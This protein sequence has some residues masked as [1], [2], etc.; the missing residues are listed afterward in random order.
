MRFAL[1]WKDVRPWTT[2]YSKTCSS[3]KVNSPY[4][5]AK[6]GNSYYNTIRV[7]LKC[8]RRVWLYTTQNNELLNFVCMYPDTLE[9]VTDSRDAYGENSDKA[10]H[11]ASMMNIFKDFDPR[12]LAVMGLAESST[13]KNWQLLDMNPGPRRVSGTLCLLGDAALTF[14]PH[15]GQGA[16]S[17]IEDA[18]SLAALF[19]TGTVQKDIPERLQLYNAIRKDRP[20]QIHAISRELGQDLEPGTE[21]ARSYREKS[22][23]EYFPLIFSHDEHDNTTQKLRE[24]LYKKRRVRWSMP[25][26]FGPNPGPIQSLYGKQEAASASSISVTFKTSRTLLQN[27]IPDHF[28]IFKGPGSVAYAS[29]GYVQFRNVSW[30]GDHGYSQLG[31]YVHGLESTIIPSKGISG[32]F[33]VVLFTDSAE[34]L[35]AERENFGIPAVYCQLSSRADGSSSSIQASWYGTTVLEICLSDLQSPRQDAPLKRIPRDDV[36]VHRWL[37]P[38][39]NAGREK[40]TG[41]LV[42]IPIKKHSSKE[43]AEGAK[44]GT[45]ASIEYMPHN[46]TILPTM[47]HIITRLAELPIYDIVATAII[48]DASSLDYEKAFALS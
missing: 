21:E 2:R 26:A 33:L 43:A 46:S 3:E 41:Q 20:E 42:R 28:L 44:I 17:A 1:C 39:P 14:L 45:K 30:L 19:P 31:F 6:I 29:L 25:T 10:N 36:F 5:S 11:K 16:A 15:I 37:P 9:D 18:A 4:G 27:L 38:F 34:V 35:V 40:V 22:A 7:V 32:S 24:F 13:V 23:K 8:Y 47:H 48:P 12:I